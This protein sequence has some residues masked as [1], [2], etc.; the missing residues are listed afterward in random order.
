MGAGSGRVTM[1]I[2][3]AGV[4]VHALDLDSSMLDALR[5]KAGALPQDVRSRLAVTQGD[6]RSF[7]IEEQFALAIIPFRAF[8]HNRTT[9]DQ[10]ACLLRVRDHLRPG[11]QL[12]FNVFHPCLLYT[13]PSPRD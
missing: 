4:R 7:A 3:E 6:M 5:R 12:A 11:G 8:L 1:P 2:L 9:E 13:S 10:L